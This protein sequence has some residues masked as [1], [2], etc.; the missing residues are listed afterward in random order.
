MRA[1]TREG[2]ETL[3]ILQ[4]LEIEV[5]WYVTPRTLPSSTNKIVRLKTGD[6]A[7]ELRQINV[8]LRKARRLRL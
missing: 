6:H 2:I 7:R 4:A 1:T 5:F 3:D 8:Y